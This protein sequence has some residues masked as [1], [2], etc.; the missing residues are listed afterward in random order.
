[1]C[2]IGEMKSCVVVLAVLWLQWVSVG[3]GSPAVGLYYDS[4]GGSSSTCHTRECPFSLCDAGKKLSGCTGASSGTC[5]PCTNTIPAGKYYSTYAPDSA[6]ECGLG[7][8]AACPQGQRRTGCGAVGSETS[9]GSCVTCGTPPAGKYW[10][11]NV[12]SLSNCPQASKT[13]CSS[14]SYTTGASDTSAGVCTACSTVTALIAKN[15]WV[16]PTAWDYVCTQLA[17]TKC[18]DGY[19]NSVVVTPQSS[20]AGICSLCPALNPNDG[21]YYGPNVDS[22]SNCPL[23]TC[24]D[25]AC[26]VGQYIKDCGVASPY[27]SPGACAACTNSIPVTKVYSTKGSWNNNCGVAECP[28]SGCNLGQYVTGCGGPPSSLGCG[29]C[30]NAVAGTSFYVGIGLSSTCGTSNCR[31]CPNGQY[32]SGCTVLVDGTCTACTN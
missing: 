9:Q 28:T 14:G 1:V 3:M 32:T 25:S 16:A 18:A 27:T 24:S 5:V 6:G 23:A 15:Y 21:Y 17:Q 13:V 10:D 8:C 4:P 30:T 29:T 2:G 12:D 20:S 31:V 26:A 19:V 7:T 22:T 11:V